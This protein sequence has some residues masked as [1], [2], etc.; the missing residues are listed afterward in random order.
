MEYP[1][2]VND[3]TNEDTVFS[4][5]VAEHEIAHTWFPFIWASMKAVTRS[6]MKAGLPRWNC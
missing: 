4:R 2:M 6:W 3:G 5:F 1:M